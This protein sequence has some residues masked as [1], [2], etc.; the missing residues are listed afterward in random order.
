MT[1]PFSIALRQKMVARL[2][3]VNAVS[4]ARLARETGIAQQ[5]LSR[6][7]SQ[8]RECCVAAS[9]GGVVS[10][11]KLEQKVR[12]L[13][14][15]SG[16]ASDELAR[17]LESEG[18]QLALFKRWCLALDEAG[19]VSVGMTKQIRELERELA[20]KDR[21]LA[22]AAVLLVLREPIDDRARNEEE[23][24]EAESNLPA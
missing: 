7:L 16:L 4:A 20:R 21:A 19:D 18:V 9:A 23:I 11:W 3:G 12:I 15:A 13:A 10:A 2:T 5:N 6:W 8:A 14:Q 1:K 17:H 24:E 22:A